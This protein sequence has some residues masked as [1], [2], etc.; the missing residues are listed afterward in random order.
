METD[1]YAIAGYSLHGVRNVY[2]KKVIRQMRESIA[3]FSDFDNCS[4]CL[5]DVY[6]LALSRIPATYSLSED[7]SPDD[8]LT[9]RE[10][11]GIVDYSIYQVLQH[12]NH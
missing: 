6:A 1:D 9:G 12:P 8:S 2:E 7:I 5:R 10:L 4:K 11:K 3:E